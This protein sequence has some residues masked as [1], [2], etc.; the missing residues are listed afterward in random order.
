MGVQQY[1]LR[2]KYRKNNFQR[3]QLIFFC[4]T[5]CL[6]LYFLYASD[7]AVGMPP[8]EVSLPG[9]LATCVHIAPILLEKSVDEGLLSSKIFSWKTP[10]FADL[11]LSLDNQEGDNSIKNLINII[12]K[13]FTEKTKHLFLLAESKLNLPYLTSSHRT[14]FKV[15]NKENLIVGNEIKLLIEAKDI[16]GK[17]TSYGGGDFFKIRVENPETRSAVAASNIVDQGNGTYVVSIKTFWS[18]RNDIKVFFGQSGHFIDLIKR[19]TSRYFALELKFEGEY[20][21][22]CNKKKKH[23]RS[24]FTREFKS[25]DINRSQFDPKTRICNY[26]KNEREEWFC[27]MP[28]PHFTCSNLH[29]VY[30]KRNQNSLALFQHF[31]VN[32]R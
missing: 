9:D 3:K 16:N 23:C 14:T 30:S 28:S 24:V 26:S 18:G 20:I 32:D 7:S 5:L 31:P 21:K 25:C 13:P 17:P 4:L 1:C 29:A 15:I 8:W 11:L 2:N 19:L 12:C 22:N 10:R 6:I 27:E